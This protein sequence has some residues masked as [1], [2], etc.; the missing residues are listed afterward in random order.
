MRTLQPRQN[1]ASISMF[2][3]AC[4][5]DVKKTSCN[6]VHAI[7]LSFIIVSLKYLM[8]AM[9]FWENIDSISYIKPSNWSNISH[10]N[11]NFYFVNKTQISTQKV[12]CSILCVIYCMP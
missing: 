2:A 4:A 6:F 11:G 9:V 5:G 7:E 8:P 10:V 12:A 3:F 1:S